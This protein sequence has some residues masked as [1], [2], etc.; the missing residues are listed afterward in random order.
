MWQ[1]RPER[2]VWCHSTYSTTH[3][4]CRCRFWKTIFFLKTRL[5]FFF[6]PTWIKWIS[7][8]TS[9]VC[10]D[11]TDVRNEQSYDFT[12]L[13]QYECQKDTRDPDCFGTFG[14]T[15]V[16]QRN[17]RLSQ[18]LSE[19]YANVF[20]RVCFLFIFIFLLRWKLCFR[21][22]QFNAGITP[23]CVLSKND[24]KKS[25]MERFLCDKCAR[26]VAYSGGLDATRG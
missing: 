19:M 9:S 25:Y 24:S 1:A 21:H 23:L 10:P 6:K 14:N 26:Y 16:F 13:V 20:F 11:W 4:A 15:S 17:S 5:H 8:L 2:T 3:R 12:A 22:G 7:T 18:R